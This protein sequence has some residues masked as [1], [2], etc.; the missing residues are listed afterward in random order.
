MTC[1]PVLQACP[2]CA[3]LSDLQACPIDS[4]QLFH[5]LSNSIFVGVSLGTHIFIKNCFNCVSSATGY[6][7]KLPVPRTV[8]SFIISLPKKL[9]FARRTDNVG[10]LVIFKSLGYFSTTV[11]G[12]CNWILLIGG[13]GFSSFCTANRF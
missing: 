2:M 1:K 6:G 9:S 12:C 5:R 7:C 8:Q 4:V 13:S 3:C 10:I 11:S